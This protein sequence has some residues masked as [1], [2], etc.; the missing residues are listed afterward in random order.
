MKY[1]NKYPPS[2]LLSSRQW[3]CHRKESRKCKANEYL[4]QFD[5]ADVGVLDVAL[6]VVDSTL[7]DQNPAV[8]AT[9]IIVRLVGP[10]SGPFGESSGIHRVPSDSY[11]IAFFELIVETHP[12]WSQILSNHRIQKELFFTVWVYD[13]QVTWW[14]ISILI[15]FVRE[16]SLNSS[17]RE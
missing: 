1:L 2:T 9:A 6:G 8:L 7:P 13:D 11:P 4:A 5:L 14:I 17:Q 10:H 16:V 12:D 15:N 3:V